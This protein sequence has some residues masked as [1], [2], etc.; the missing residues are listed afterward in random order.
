[1]SVCSLLTALADKNYEE[2]AG[3]VHVA[4]N[5]LHRVQQQ[6]KKNNSAREKTRTF[7]NIFFLF[8][9]GSISFFCLFSFSLVATV[10]FTEPR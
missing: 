5:R 2:Y 1:M 4:V 7:F 6:Q 8:S 10:D 3:A 9:L